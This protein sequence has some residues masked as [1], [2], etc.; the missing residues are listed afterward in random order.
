M[1]ESR[2]GPRNNKG[3]QAKIWLKVEK[4]REITKESR[5]KYG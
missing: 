5:P 1:V 3:E 4:D 2:R